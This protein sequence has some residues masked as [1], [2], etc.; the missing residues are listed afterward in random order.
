MISAF[1]GD[2]TISRIL[3]HQKM[4]PSSGQWRLNKTL[5]RL[6][7]WFCGNWMFAL[8]F[9][10]QEIGIQNANNNINIE[11]DEKA[12]L[13]EMIRQ[14]D[15]EY[16][17]NPNLPLLF[18]NATNWKGKPFMK[19]IDFIMRNVNIPDFNEQAIE[20]CKEE[21]EIINMSTLTIEKKE[22]SERYIK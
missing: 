10:N 6:G 2:I 12:R 20:M 8:V 22:R 5:D 16:M 11:S 17:S 14:H 3:G 13:V 18:S 9:W 7:C 19:L 1:K 15:P 4:M 21:L